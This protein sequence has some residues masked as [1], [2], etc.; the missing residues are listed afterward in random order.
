[1]KFNGKLVAGDL[2]SVRTKLE[3]TVAYLQSNL[4]EDTW[5]TGMNPEIPEK[6]ILTNPY[7]YRRDTATPPVH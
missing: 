5:K 6:E 7:Q 1:V 3:N 2:P 4:G